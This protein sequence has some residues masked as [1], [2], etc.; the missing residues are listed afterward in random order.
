M[1]PS[2]SGGPGQDAASISFRGGEGRGQEVLRGGLAADLVAEEIDSK[3]KKEER[4]EL[5]GK[6]Q[7]IESE[8][9]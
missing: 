9:P 4:K 3:D 7:K 6:A 5:P 2:V 1:G 8:R